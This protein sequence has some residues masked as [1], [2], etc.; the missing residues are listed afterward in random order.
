VS[1]RFSAWLILYGVLMKSV[2]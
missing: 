2:R 1:C